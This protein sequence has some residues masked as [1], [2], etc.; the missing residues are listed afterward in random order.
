MSPD[1]SLDLLFDPSLIP[2][3]ICDQLGDD[4]QVRIRDA[5]ISDFRSVL[6]L[7]L[8]TPEVI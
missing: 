7:R 6:W 4:L 5:A 2:S 8:I 1:T 3:S